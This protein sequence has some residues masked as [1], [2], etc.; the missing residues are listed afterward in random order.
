MA[1]MLDDL[2]DPSRYDRN[3]MVVWQGDTVV[4]CPGPNP[5]E[6]AREVTEQLRDALTLAGVDPARIAVATR[7]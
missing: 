3:V 1:T 4:L 2:E 5:D 6:V 7:V